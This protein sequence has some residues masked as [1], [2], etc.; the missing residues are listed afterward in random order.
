MVYHRSITVLSILPTSRGE[1]RDRNLRVGFLRLLLASAT[2]AGFFANT[3]AFASSLSAS[4][5]GNVNKAAVSQLAGAAGTGLQ[6]D[7]ALAALG[8]KLGGNELA[9]DTG[10]GSYAAS[11]D[12]MRAAAGAAAAEQQSAS[13]KD[14]GIRPLSAGHLD[15]MESAAFRAGD[16]FRYVCPDRRYPA[17]RLENVRAD[18]R[19][20]SRTRDFSVTNTI[21][22]RFDVEPVLSIQRPG[23]PPPPLVQPWPCGGAAI[24][25]SLFSVR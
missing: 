20:G 17:G 12:V 13:F 8:V 9:S 11:V 16:A 2:A 15:A 4:S 5:S 21:R 14:G 24:S 19:C 23:D 1:G 10:R 25:V 7:G 22:E 18:G 6:S 3:A